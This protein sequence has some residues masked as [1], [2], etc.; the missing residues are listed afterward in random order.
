VV[1]RG[2]LSH[3]QVICVLSVPKVPSLVFL[4]LMPMGPSVNGPR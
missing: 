3:T 4:S 2:L 1:I